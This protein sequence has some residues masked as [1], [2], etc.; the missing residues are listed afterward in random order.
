[1]RIPALVLIVCT[2]LNQNILQAETSKH[3]A[4]LK[5]VE[6]VG[7]FAGV[8]AAGGLVYTY[9]QI[10]SARASEPELMRIKNDLLR[11]EALDLHNATW[12]ERN[13][14]PGNRKQIEMLRRWQS[15][16]E[17]NRRILIRRQVRG[18]KFG[19]IAGIVSG[20]FMLF[21][22][23]VES[24]ESKPTKPELSTSPKTKLGMH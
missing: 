16:A 10:M 24:L 1:M 13:N 6:T 22:Y 12:L 11:L 19:G 15:E 7:K 21:P 8:A 5:R 14:D 9:N 23:L 20:T 3:E 2:L 4:G 18:L 17:G